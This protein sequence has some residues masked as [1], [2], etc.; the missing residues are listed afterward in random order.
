MSTVANVAADAPPAAGGQDVLAEARRVLRMEAEAVAGVGERLGESVVRAVELI[1]ETDGMV[2]VSGVG[3]SGLIARKVAAT[4]TSTGTPAVFMH[5]V[6][7]LHGDLGIASPGNVMILLSRSGATEE[8]KGLVAFAEMRGMPL[9]ALVGDT[10]SPLARR[11]AAVLDCGVP[12]EA[13]PMDLAPTSSTTAALAMGDAL[14]V[15]LLRRRGFCAADFA[16]IHPGGSLGRRLTLRV[17]DVMVAEDYPAVTEDATVR[18]IIVP[19]ARMRGTVPV[20]D[21]DNT[22]VGVI[23]A[24]DVA[25]LMERTEDFLGLGVSTFMTRT[26][27]TAR[28]EEPGVTAVRRME[29]CGVMALPVVGDAGLEG[30][31]HLHDLLRAGAV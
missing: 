2:V 14:A 24:G 7:G 15:A 29:Q 22:L 16:R 17:R 30:I 31:V 26:P 23:T 25:R 12:A 19:L 18:E 4:L 6:D 3:K 8:L 13:C 28:A 9:I 27:R 1:S 5:P 10:G 20:I 21:G 11:A